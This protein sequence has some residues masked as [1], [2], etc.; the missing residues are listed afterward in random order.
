MGILIKRACGGVQ[1]TLSF[2]ILYIHG[3][4]SLHLGPCQHNMPP[5]INVKGSF[6]FLDVQLWMIMIK[7]LLSETSGEKGNSYSF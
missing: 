1:T 2:S 5:V 3:S 4:G 7:S 6:L